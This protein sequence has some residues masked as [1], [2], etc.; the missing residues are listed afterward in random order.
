MP[1]R[2]RPKRVTSITTINEKKVLGRDIQKIFEISL[3]VRFLAG[4]YF[5]SFDGRMDTLG[6]DD[7]GNSYII[8][9]EKGQNENL[10]NEEN[11]HVCVGYSTIRLVPRSLP[12]KGRRARDP[13]GC[14]TGDLCSRELQQV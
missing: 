3:D 7:D 14:S 4:E 6:I 9:Y 10:I 12:G 2:T 8:E 11:S 5:I 13:V 1:V